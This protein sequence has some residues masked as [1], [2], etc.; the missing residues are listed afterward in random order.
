MKIILQLEELV[1]WFDYMIGDLYNKNKIKVEKNTI[2]FCFT[3]KIACVREFCPKEVLDAPKW[4]DSATVTGLDFNA[5]GEIV[6]TY[7][8]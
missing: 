1:K 4:K 7:G 2:F 6:A 3:V 8:R 5:E